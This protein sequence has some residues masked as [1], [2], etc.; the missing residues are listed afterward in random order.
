MNYFSTTWSN[1]LSKRHWFT[2]D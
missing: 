2:Y 1:S